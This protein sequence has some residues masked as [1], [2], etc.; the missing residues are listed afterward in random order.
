M[1]TSATVL[2][3]LTTALEAA[4]E[5]FAETDDPFDFEHQP[6]ITRDQVYRL[7]SELTGREGYL[8][9]YALEQ[10]SVTAYL[11]RRRRGSAKAAAVLLRADLDALSVAWVRAGHTNGS[12][13]VSSEDQDGGVVAPGG[14]EQEYLVARLRVAVEFDRAL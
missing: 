3:A 5:G 4:C 8:G 1:A 2:A 9:N 11:A 13:E 10:W 14:E 12:Y 6:T 7:E